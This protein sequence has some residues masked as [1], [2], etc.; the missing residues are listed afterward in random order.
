MRR[1]VWIRFSEPVEK[2]RS[3]LESYGF[4]ANERSW[5]QTVD[6]AIDDE[7]LEPFVENLRKRGTS[8]TALRHISFDENDLQAAEYLQMSAEVQWGYPQP[9][10]DY[11]SVSYD[12]STKCD[13]CG[14][15]ALQNRP[16]LL[17]SRPSFSK[18]DIL[19]M[20]W[21]YEFLVTARFREV[22]EDA[23]LTGAEFWP[24]L[25]YSKGGSS[26]QIHEAYQL[27]VTNELPPMS[28]NT[29]FEAVEFPSGA[30]ECQCGKLGRN[31]K[32]EPMIFKY[33]ALSDAKDFNKTHEWLG[34]GYGTTQWKVVSREVY[35]LFSEGKIRGAVFEPALIEE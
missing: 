35:R 32:G 13:K 6:I 1:M 23:G 18:N 27:H 14:Q 19:S 22:V 8:Y 4:K 34:G 2:A 20:F 21:T 3:L 5:I 16:F 17:K 24:L 26:R 11:E 12:S 28:V 33:G 10:D 31:L 25:K 7:R 29:Q 15:G 9:E 30:E